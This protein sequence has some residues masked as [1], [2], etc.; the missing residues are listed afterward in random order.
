MKLNQIISK[1]PLGS[2]TLF[3]LSLT[4]VAACAPSQQQ[5]DAAVKD[6]IEKNPKVLEAQ[7]NKVL[8]EKGIRGRRPQ[9]TIDE[10]IKNPVKVGLN[11]APFK[12]SEDAEITIVEF[13]DFQC[14][15][16]KKV[17]PTIDEIMKKNKGKIKFAFRQNPLPFHKNAMSAAKASLAAD[18][19][20]KFWEMHDALFENQ[21]NLTDENIKKLAKDLGLNVAQFEKDWKGKKF[22]VQIQEDLKFAKSSGATG[23]PSFFING[24]F[25]RGARPANYFQQVI[26]KLQAQ[27]K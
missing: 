3:I 14:P 25:V 21:R 19:Q 26:D 1:G 5:M 27:K 4:L 9:K 17:N 10:M 7:I 16:C 11:N 23:T 8:K 18:A 24:V 6:Y 2:L 12:G 22:D 15:F 20:G 13:S